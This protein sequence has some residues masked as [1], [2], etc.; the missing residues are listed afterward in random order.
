MSGQIP[1]YIQRS[2]EE[3]LQSTDNVKDFPM[4]ELILYS[5]P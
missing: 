3:F 1:R 5:L 2:I 4:N